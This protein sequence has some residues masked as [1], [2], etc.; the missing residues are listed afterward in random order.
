MKSRA[1]LTKAADWARQNKYC[2]C[3]LAVLLLAALLAFWALDAHRSVQ[4]SELRAEYAAT[5]EKLR[6]A[7]AETAAARKELAEKTAELAAQQA[8]NDRRI[9]EVTSNAYKQ[10]RAL[11]DDDLLAAYNRLI[12]GARSRNADRERT[13]S[14]SEE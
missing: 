2:L 5:A 14:S 13:D 1:I 3:V 4:L 9:Q 10:A 7:E 6:A 11:G 12:T 8:S